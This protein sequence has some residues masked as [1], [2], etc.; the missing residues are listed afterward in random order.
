MRVQAHRLP[1]ADPTTQHLGLGRDF[2]AETRMC[3]FAP[4]HNFFFMKASRFICW[5]LHGPLDMESGRQ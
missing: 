1:R 3:V 5:F 4:L 2:L